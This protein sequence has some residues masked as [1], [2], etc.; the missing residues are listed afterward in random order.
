MVLDQAWL[1]EHWPFL[2]GAFVIVV[3]NGYLYV[4]GGEEWRP[5]GPP[6]L[7]AIVVVLLIE[8]ARTLYRRHG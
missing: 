8:V 4:S 5:G 7:I 3:G 1:R 6:L 2:V